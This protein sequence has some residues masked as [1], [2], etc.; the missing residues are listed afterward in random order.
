MVEVWKNIDLYEGYQVSNYGR[1]KSVDRTIIRNDG[2]TAKMPEKILKDR[3]NRVGYSYI[4]I[5]RKN[6]AVHRLVATAFLDKNENQTDVNHKNCIKS[7]NSASNLEWCTK[8]ENTRHALQNDRF[9]RKYGKDNPLSLKI[10]Q[11][12]KQSGSLVKIW[13]SLSDVKRELGLDIKSLVY[14]CKGKIYKS[15]GGY[16]WEYQN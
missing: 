13:D 4:C 15:V 8:K 10:R 9:L 14:C 3:Y 7:D 12:S 11:I 1:V 2:R 16:K 6:Y 5:N